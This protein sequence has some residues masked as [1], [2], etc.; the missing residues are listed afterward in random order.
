MVTRLDHQAAALLHH[1]QRVRGGFA[2]VHGNQGAV[3][4]GGD[5]A[6][7]FTV[8][9][10]EVA[11]HAHALGHVDQVGLETDQAAH[12]SQRLDR[13]EIA[14]VGHVGDLALAEGQVLHD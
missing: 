1:V 13:H 12:R 11:E 9:V 3:L 4:A 5:L 10:E 6:A 14:G 7:V 2:G 8:L